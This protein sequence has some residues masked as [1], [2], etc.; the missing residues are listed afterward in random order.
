MMVKA[1]TRSTSSSSGSL[2]LVGRGDILIDGGNSHFAD[3]IRRTKAVEARGLLYVG[4]GVSGGEEG[5]LRGPSLMPGGSPAAWPAIRPIFEKIAARGA[6]RNALRGLGRPGRRRPLRQDGPQRHRV[7]R[8]AAHRRE[9]R[10]DG[11][12]PGDGRG[13]DERGVRGLE[14]RRPRELP[15]GHHGRDPGLQGRG[16]HAARRQDP[17][18]GGPEGHGQVG[19]HG[20]PRPRRAADARQRGRL[21]PVPLGGEGSAGRGGEGPPGDGAAPGGGRA[22]GFPRRPR[23]GALRGESRLLRPGVR[24][25]PG[26]GRRVPVGP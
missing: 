23:E 9:L 26:G 11:G 22:G 4:T 3:T 21:R 24:P 13:R 5:A 18:H 6:G 25:A 19:E 20:R 2:P 17:R 14:P 7:R 1:G 10:A 15:R 8:H 12:A 16:R